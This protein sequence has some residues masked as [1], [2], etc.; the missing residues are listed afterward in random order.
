MAPNKLCWIF[1]MRYATSQFTISIVVLVKYFVC[2]KIS[3]TLKETPSKNVPQFLRN[4]SFASLPL[5]NDAYHKV[6]YYFRVEA[7]FLSLIVSLTEIFVEILLVSSDFFEPFKTYVQLIMIVL[8]TC[9]N[10]EI[11]L[12]QEFTLQR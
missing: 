11:K 2:Q 4:D 7:I 10:C 3:I 9:Y 6:M 12:L 8:I 1:C 5:L